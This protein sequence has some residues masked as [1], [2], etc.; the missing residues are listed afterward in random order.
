MDSRD[1][2]GAAYTRQNIPVGGFGGGGRLAGGDQPV[3]AF[4]HIKKHGV[5]GGCADINCQ[6]RIAFDQGW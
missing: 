5:R 3:F 2:N 4:D 6:E 1:S